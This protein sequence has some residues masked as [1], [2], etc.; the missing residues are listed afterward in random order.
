MKIQRGIFLTA[1]VLFAAAA[2]QAQSI[3]GP[4]TAEISFT[5]VRLGGFASNQF[6]VW[7]E[8][9]QGRHVKTLYAT[10]YTANGGWERR[11]NSIPQ[12]VKQSG[13]ASMN[14]AQ[15]DALSGPTPK[16][17]TQRFVWNGTNQA[18]LAVSTGSYR[19]FVE[20]TLRND[21]RVLYTAEIRLGEHGTVNAQGRYFG[22]RT[23]DRKMIGEVT[24]NY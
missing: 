23:A 10:R 13:L 2:L 1:A 4:G 11:P 24:V 12:W 22:D 21:N 9:A 5:Y 14:K 17:G 8:D 19:L 18:G 15:I 7:I 6:A 20:A 16:S 3:P